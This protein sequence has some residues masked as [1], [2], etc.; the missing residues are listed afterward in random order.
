MGV[1][2]EQEHDA[3]FGKEFEEPAERR[4]SCPALVGAALAVDV[5]G[6]GVPGDGVGGVDSGLVEQRAEPSGGRV[7]VLDAEEPCLVVIGVGDGGAGAG[8]AQDP[9]DPRRG[10]AVD[11]RDVREPAPSVPDEVVDAC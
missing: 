2:A 4:D 11:G 7:V 6:I 1:V 10:S 9:Q 5:P 3:E 8:V